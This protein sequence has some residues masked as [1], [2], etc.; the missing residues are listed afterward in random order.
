MKHC[1]DIVAVD[2]EWNEIRI[3]IRIR[4]IE[5]KKYN[6]WTIRSTEYPKLL[7]EDISLY[8][9]CYEEDDILKQIV[10]IN[11]PAIKKYSIDTLRKERQLKYNED[12]T[13]FIAIP[14]Q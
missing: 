6:D 5:Y 11:V 3:G 12:G 7:N 2:S 4:K 13:S 8:L 14:F 1:T 9:Y 10:C